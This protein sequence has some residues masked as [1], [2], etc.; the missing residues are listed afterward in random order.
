M[1]YYITLSYI[2]TIILYYIT[3]ILLY[4]MILR[5]TDTIILYYVTLTLLYYIILRYTIILYYVLPAQW[6]SRTS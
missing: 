2:N 3:L 5:Y 6:E 4:Y 1:L